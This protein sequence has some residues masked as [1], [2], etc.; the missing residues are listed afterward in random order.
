MMGLIP[1]QLACFGHV[2][3]LN[4]IMFSRM[5]KQ[6]R[7]GTR[8]TRQKGGF[9]CSTIMSAYSGSIEKMLKDLIYTDEMAWK[10][11][12]PSNKNPTEKKAVELSIL[13]KG[14]RSWM[15]FGKA[16]QQKAEEITGEN[17]SLK[18]ILPELMTPAGTRTPDNEALIDIV[19]RKLNSLKLTGLPH[20]YMTDDC[21]R[22][23][24]NYILEKIKTRQDYMDA[25]YSNNK[26]YVYELVKQKI[27]D[28]VNALCNNDCDAIGRR[29]Y[30]TDRSGKKRC[31]FDEEILYRYRSGGG[32]KRKIRSLKKKTRKTKRTSK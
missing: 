4:F 30:A 6:K 19:L 11:L 14:E 2:D 1:Q 15:N 17:L 23:L 10:Y 18:K 28:I 22:D 9:I 3:M 25:Y 13:P 26:D 12:Q 16:L 7:S 32:S 20:I 8:K 31:S 21:S 29:Y 27:L 24:V 5:P